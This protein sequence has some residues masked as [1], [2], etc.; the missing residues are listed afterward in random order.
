M[1]NAQKAVC[2][3]THTSGLNNPGAKDAAHC[4]GGVAA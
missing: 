2:V 3:Y 4:K 1:S